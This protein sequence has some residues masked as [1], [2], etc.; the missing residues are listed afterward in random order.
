MAI[1]DPHKVPSAIAISTNWNQHSVLDL[2]VGKL[3]VHFK[4]RKKHFFK[5]KYFFN[6]NWRAIAVLWWFL[7]ISTWIS[8]RGTCV[9]SLLIPSSTSPLNPIPLRCHRALA[10]GSLH[11]KLTILHMVIYMFQCYPLL[12]WLCPKVCSS[13]L[14]LFCCPAYRFIKTIFLDSIYMH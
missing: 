5:K 11:H 13:C 2:Q 4:G 6:F 8:H 12:L 7:H 3:L 1:K 10:L 9:P 14:C